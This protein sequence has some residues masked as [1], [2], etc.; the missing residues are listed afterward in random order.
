[1]TN[2]S[3]RLRV[4]GQTLEGSQFPLCCYFANILERNCSGD[5]DAYKNI[6]NNYWI[7]NTMTFDCIYYF[8]L[9][10]F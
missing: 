7:S 1:M 6:V 4:F 8:T 9:T 3:R 5:A 10:I 2:Q